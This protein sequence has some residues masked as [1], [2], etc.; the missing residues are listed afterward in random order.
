[1]STLGAPNFLNSLSLL[2][3]AAAAA[4]TIGR[5]LASPGKVEGRGAEPTAFLDAGKVFEK[6]K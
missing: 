2:T 1:M 6:F 4:A 5:Y 3:L